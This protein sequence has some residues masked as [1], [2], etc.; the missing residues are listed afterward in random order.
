[1][2]K[3]EFKRRLKKVNDRIIEKRKE[4][5]LKYSILDGSA[6]SVMAGF[7][8]TYIVP[9]ALALKAT[10]QQIAM[11]SSV[12][13]LLGS[14]FQLFSAKVLTIVK[15]RKKIINYSVF[16]QALVWLP[17]FFLPFFFREYSLTFLIFFVCL[18]WIFGQFAGPAWNSLMGDLVHENNRGEYFGKRN[19]I[20]GFVAFISVFVAGIILDKLSVVSVWLGFF[21]L[22]MV[23]MF[24][25]FVSLYYLNKMYE[26]PYI[27]KKTDHFTF[28]DFLKRLGKTNYSNFVI[29][30]I[31]T[32]FAVQVSAPFFAVYMLK[33]LNLSYFHYTLIISAA[34]VS[35]F[36]SMVYWGR[37]IDKF[38][39]K[40][41]L[42]A[43][44]ILTAIVPIN[45]LFSSKVV[46]LVIIQVF[47][48]F[49]W[50]GFNLAAFN[51]VFETVRPGKRARAVA[52]QNVLNGGAIFI[53]AN[54]GGVLLS[55]SSLPAILG[56][57]IKSIFL[58]SGIL[59]LLVTVLFLPRIKEPR[60]EFNKKQYAL[61]WNLVAIQPAQGL[62]YQATVGM[63]KSI[64]GL[65]YGINIIDKIR[66]FRIKKEKIFKKRF[67]F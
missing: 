35:T 27:I 5:S 51:F 45:W 50:A 30:L 66:K 31:L 64:R 53:G 9:F 23:A 21:I 11:L 43:C 20:T 2:Q 61:F 4:K 47:A 6:W 49:A 36:I 56:F 67:K 46:Y 54:I 57:Q 38:G 34:T 29:Y 44:G 12:P 37:N 39:T 25:R 33:D 15:T 65:K 48:G 14:V 42:T 62:V 13:Q 28:P 3:E 19:K 40:N 8:E 58:I 22:F 41:V 26:P 18:Y 17:T 55:N 16:L 10:N 1:M 32:T 24:A 52:Y 60:I 7:G 59:R 63:R